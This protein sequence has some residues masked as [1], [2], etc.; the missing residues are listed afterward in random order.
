MLPACCGWHGQRHVPTAASRS[1]RGRA[2]TPSAA[3][4]C[5][6]ATQAISPH[7]LN[8]QPVDMSYMLWCVA[9]RSAQCSGVLSPYNNPSSTL[10][11]GLCTLLDLIAC[12]LCSD[13][14]RAASCRYPTTTPA[15]LRCLKRSA[16][17]YI[18]VAL[19]M[20]ALVAYMA[21]FVYLPANFG[22]CPYQIDISGC[23]NHRVCRSEGDQCIFTAHMHCSEI[24]HTILCTPSRKCFRVVAETARLANRR[25]RSCSCQ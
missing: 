10:L 21:F 23:R 4:C 19:L 11:E 18:L 7:C 3:V 12:H 25:Y 14:P 17:V 9:S 13:A 16:V 24:S 6:P 1:R 20:F 15:S 8:Q 2:W 5:H 22:Y